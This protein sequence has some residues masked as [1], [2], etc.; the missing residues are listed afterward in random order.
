MPPMGRTMKRIAIVVAAGFVL[1]GCATSTLQSKTFKSYRVGETKT[2]TIGDAFLTD[3]NG[4]VSTVREWVGVLNSPDGWRVSQRAS[5]DFV[6]KELLYS[7]KSAN[8][9][10]VSYREFRGGFAAPAFSQNLEYD[11]NESKTI[12]FQ[13]FTLEVLSATNQAITY[14]VVKD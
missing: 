13:K 2:A 6:R 3:Q 7:G 1:V 8:T 14:K 5:Q 4:S 11:L 12:N 10:K 9:I